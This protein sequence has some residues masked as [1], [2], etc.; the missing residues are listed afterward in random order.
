MQHGQLWFLLP[1]FRP[2]CFTR[3]TLLIA[4]T[5]GY[6]CMCVCVDVFIYF[7]TASVRRNLLCAPSPIESFS[8]LS[9]TLSHTSRSVGPARP[10]VSVNGCLCR[11][12]WRWLCGFVDDALV[13]PK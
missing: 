6:L 7:K 1:L 2:W 5:R 3:G 13:R 10:S 8:T 9:L 4:P 12:R 11:R